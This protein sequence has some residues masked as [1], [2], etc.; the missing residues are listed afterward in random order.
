MPWA[1]S[2]LRRSSNSLFNQYVILPLLG[3]PF[4]STNC[5]PFKSNAI[6]T[7]PLPSACHLTPKWGYCS[8]ADAWATDIPTW[9]SPTPT[10]VTT[11]VSLIVPFYIT[12]SNTFNTMSFSPKTCFHE[13]AQCIYTQQYLK[14][15]QESM[16]YI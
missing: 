4:P 2:H 10:V 13:S 8:D 14:K 7:F 3:L 1:S 12:K 11:Y 16:C 9:E 15:F 6:C 5:S